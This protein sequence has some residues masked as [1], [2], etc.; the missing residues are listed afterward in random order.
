[1]E[2][3]RTIY[4]LYLFQEK[5]V[6]EKLRR[7]YGTRHRRQTSAKTTT[8]ERKNSFVRRRAKSDLLGGKLFVTQDDRVI[9]LDKQERLSDEYD[10][11]TKC[12][13]KG[14]F[15]PDYFSKIDIACGAYALKI[16]RYIDLIPHSHQSIF[17]KFFFYS[18]LPHLNDSP[19]SCLIIPRLLRLER[20]FLM[21]YF[22]VLDR[23]DFR[24]STILCNAFDEIKSVKLRVYTEYHY[25]KI[26]STSNNDPIYGLTKYDLVYL[27]LKLLEKQQNDLEPLTVSNDYPCVIEY[28]SLHQET[29]Y[30]RINK[31]TE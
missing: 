4:R 5:K 29:D 31:T 13:S 16:K 15:F 8:K 9:D 7:A 12:I 1:M 10:L 11:K 30:T 25:F 23:K 22:L 3:H 14:Y 19:L 28:F 27:L 17:K 18:A 2:K 6:R 24:N 26:F 21:S 20:G